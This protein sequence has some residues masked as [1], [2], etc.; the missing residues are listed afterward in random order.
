MSHGLS[1][2]MPDILCPDEIEGKYTQA[3]FIK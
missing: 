1:N 2:I 3:N